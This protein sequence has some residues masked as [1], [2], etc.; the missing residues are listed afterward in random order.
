V[1]TTSI[2]KQF[3][4]EMRSNPPPETGLRN[5]TGGAVVRVVGHATYIIYSRLSDASMDEAIA[6]EAASVAARRRNVEWKIYGHDEPRALSARLAAHGFEADEPETLMVLDLAR[7]LPA[8]SG[9]GIVIR[10]VSD[11]AGLRDLIAVQT[12]V[13]EHDHTALAD[14]FRARLADPTLGLYVAYSDGT[15]VAAGRLSLPPRRSFAGLWGGGT[16]EGFRRR[17]IYRGMVHARA[18]EARAQGYRYLT[19]E[20]R[21]TSRPILQRLGF[22]PLTSVVGWILRPPASTAP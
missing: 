1:D 18:S 21:E 19:V 5:E 14:E 4:A 12:A 20:A 6:A 10:R 7:D 8:A 11:E 9:L 3:D 2:L 15:P 13:F 22:V 16:M 17:G